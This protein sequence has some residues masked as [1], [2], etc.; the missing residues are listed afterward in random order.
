MGLD[1]VPTNRPKPG[2]EA[3]FEDIFNV[4][5]KK[6]KAGF[7]AS[8]FAKPV[9]MEALAL[10]SQEISISAYE[11]LKAPIVGSDPRADEWARKYYEGLEDK[12]K[13]LD[14]FMA[15]MKGYYVLDLVP[16]CDGLPVY[17]SPTLERHAFRAKFL[18]DCV[19]IIG[20]DM[21][22]DAWNS[23]LPREAMVYG[24]KLMQLDTDYGAAN[25]CLFPKGQRAYPEVEEGSPQ[26][27]AHILFSAAKWILFW[28][29]KGHGMEANF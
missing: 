13:P 1:W 22:A 6:K 12:T 7:W 10:R 8:L 23:K 28:A 19:D 24:N 25:D 3:E 26:S 29:E 2:A 14:E 17:V 9:D 11:T 20:D 4:F 21:H 16:D 5:F 15:E 27:K 18:D